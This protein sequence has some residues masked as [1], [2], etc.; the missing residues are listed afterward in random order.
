MAYRLRHTGDG[1]QMTTPLY[2]TKNT[3]KRSIDKDGNIITTNTATT[4]GSIIKGKP[5]IPAVKPVVKLPVTKYSPTGPGETQDQANIRWQKRLDNQPPPVPTPPKPPTPGG[6]IVTTS[7]S[8]GT[9]GTLGTPDIVTPPKVKVSSTTEMKPVSMSE[10]TTSFSNSGSYNNKKGISIRLP[11][12]NLGKI[13][14]PEIN[15][16]GLRNAFSKKCTGC[17]T[18]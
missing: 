12:I 16:R 15:T 13:N 1:P 6:K 10:S 4:P 11:K 8:N 7:P 18:N 3:S 17:G 2:Q 5:P 14:L 9:P